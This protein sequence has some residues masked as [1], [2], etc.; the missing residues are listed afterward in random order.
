MQNHREKR[1]F[2]ESNAATPLQEKFFETSR[3]ERYVLGKHIVFS[4]G[5][6]VGEEIVIQHGERMSYV[7]GKGMG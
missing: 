6:G 4:L 1:K 3:W 7:L 5:L 2:R